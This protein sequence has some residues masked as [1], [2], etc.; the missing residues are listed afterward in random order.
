[1]VTRACLDRSH[2]RDCA[3]VGNET[4]RFE[5]GLNGQRDPKKK[6]GVEKHLP[7]NTGRSF[8]LAI[9]VN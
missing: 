1:M 5:N 3:R 9:R 7:F 4:E 2:C 8:T 6:P